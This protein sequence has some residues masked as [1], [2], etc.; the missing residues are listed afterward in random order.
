MSRT[1]THAEYDDMILQRD[2]WRTRCLKSEE[3]RDK[4]YTKHQ[5]QWR[6]HHRLLSTHHELERK[7]WDLE[8]KYAAALKELGKR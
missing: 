2:Y 1:Y 3:E 6:E 4:Y 5:E 7:K 8:Q